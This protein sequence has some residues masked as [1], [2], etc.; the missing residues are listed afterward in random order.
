M[1][2]DTHLLD[3]PIKRCKD[4]LL[5]LT[6]VFLTLPA[7]AGPLYFAMNDGRLT[8]RLPD[9]EQA[10]SIDLAYAEVATLNSIDGQIWVYGKQRLQAYNP[11]GNRLI[12]QHYPNLPAGNSASDLAVG[13]DSVWL[14]IGRT[15]YRFDEEGRLIKRR[16]IGA[17]IQSI[18]FDIKESCILIETPSQVVILNREG[19]E[20][21]RIRIR[22]PNIA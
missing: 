6:L 9:S 15:L 16:S 3:T 21:K 10:I 8:D 1:N 18:H 13:Y 11:D 19:E 2:R 12:D 22:L 20:V 14:A 5:V 4:C 17:L 7:T